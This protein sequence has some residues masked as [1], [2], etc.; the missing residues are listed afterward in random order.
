MLPVFASFAAA[1]GPIHSKELMSSP[2]ERQALIERV[3]SEFI[4]MLGLRQSVSQAARLWGLDLDGL[5]GR[6]C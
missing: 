5:L 2:G 3:R 1:D 4:E 6:H